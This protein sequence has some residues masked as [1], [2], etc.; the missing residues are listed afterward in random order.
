MLFLLI[1]I[2]A[3]IL[4]IIFFRPE[5]DKLV[6]TYLPYLKRYKEAKRSRKNLYNEEK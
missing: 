6:F 3:F 4:I 5:Q 1:Y 2:I